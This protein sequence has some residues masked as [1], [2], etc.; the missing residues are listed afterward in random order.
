MKKAVTIICLSLSAILILDSVNAGHAVFMF[1]LAGV[2]PG[3]NM[4]ISADSMLLSF[5][6]LTGFTLSRIII[7]VARFA[8]KEKTQSSNGTML[9]AQS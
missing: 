9:S 8:D 1:F 5:T 3:T 4:A 6:F 2:I 7:N